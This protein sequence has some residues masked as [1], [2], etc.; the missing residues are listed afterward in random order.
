MVAGDF[1]AA[2][3]AND[4]VNGSLVSQ[5]ETRDLSTLLDSTD[6]AELE[7]VGWYYSW[8]SK[9]LNESRTYSRI[10]RVLGNAEWKGESPT[11]TT[12]YLNPSLSD[13]CPM[14]VVCS[15]DDNTGGR[16]FQF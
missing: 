16:P 4:R 5:T 11:V 13:H 14:L 9:G 2:L 8:S 6:L 3:Y 7:S 12:Q 15:A 1:N 10:D